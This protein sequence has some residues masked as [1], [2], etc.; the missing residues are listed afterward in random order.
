MRTLLVALTLFAL[1][2]SA[3][4]W[5]KITHG[6]VAQVIVADAS[7]IA[8]RTDGPWVLTPFKVGIGWPYDGKKFTNPSIS[9]YT[10]AGST[11]TP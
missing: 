6:K 4:E 9:T 2:V 11:P 3:G 8:K 10:V 5:A 1:P 7:E